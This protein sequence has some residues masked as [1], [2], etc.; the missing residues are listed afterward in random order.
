MESWKRN[1]TG[2]GFATV[3][4]CGSAVA[5]GSGGAGWKPYSELNERELFQL[6]QDLYELNKK[7][8]AISWYDPVSYFAVGGGEPTKGKAKFEH[9]YR[10]VVYRF[11]SEANLALFKATPEKFEPAYGGWCAYAMSHE[12]FTEPYPKRF[13]IQNGRLMLFYTS[14]VTDTLDSWNEEGPEKLE[15]RADAYWEMQLQERA[16]DFE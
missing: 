9:E 10:G 12:S 14:W 15:P 2:M 11:V 4:L 7:H 6:R 1:V 3:L 5:W 16:D 13:V 8:L